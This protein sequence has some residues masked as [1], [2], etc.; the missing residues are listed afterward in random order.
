MDK[1]IRFMDKIKVNCWIRG[2]SY[3]VKRRWP[4][5]LCNLCGHP[6][7]KT[8]SGMHMDAH[9]NKIP[10]KQE[11]IKFIKSLKKEN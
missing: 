3:K 10:T 1:R 11:T 4:K 2:K 9:A 6:M 7:G 8:N 5:K